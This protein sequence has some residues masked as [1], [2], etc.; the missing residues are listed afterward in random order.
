[1]FAS[2]LVLGVLFLFGMGWS[3]KAEPVIYSATQDVPAWTNQTSPVYHF[4]V[5]QAY[6]LQALY[7]DGNAECFPRM[8]ARIN[9]NNNW[10]FREHYGS[11]YWYQI[12]LWPLPNWFVSNCHFSVATDQYDENTISLYHSVVNVGFKVDTSAPNT[13]THNWPAHNYLNFTNSITLYSNTTTDNGA[14]PAW[15]SGISGYQMRINGSTTY[16][17][18]ASTSKYLDDLSDN[19]YTRQIRA[20]DNAGNRSDWSSS[21]TF[22]IDTTPPSTPS[23]S[24]PANGSMYSGNTV[25][26]SWSSASDTNGI[27]QYAI[28]YT[29]TTYGGTTTSYSAS[30]SAT[31]NFAALTDGVYS[32]R[33]RAQD[34]ATNRWNWSTTRTFIVDRTAPASIA[35]T[36][37]LSNAWIR[38]SNDELLLQYTIT[39][40]LGFDLTYGPNSITIDYSNQWDFVLPTN[41]VSWAPNDGS[42]TRTLPKNQNTNAAKF[43]ITATDL[44]GW[45]STFY[46]S[47]FNIDSIKP[48]DVQFSTPHQSSVYKWWEYISSYI[49]WYD[50]N[51]TSTWT[52]YELLIND[53]HNRYLDFEQQEGGA[54]WF[55]QYKWTAPSDINSQHVKI[56]VTATDK[57]WR[58]NN[59]TSQAFTIDNTA[60][61]LSFNDTSS[62]WTN[63]NKTWSTTVG[64][65]FW[66]RVTGV[67]VY[68]TTAFTNNCDG[69][70][71]TVPV[72]TWDGTYT[73]Y[74]C[75]ADKAGNVTTG[76][77][78]YNIDKTAPYVELTSTTIYTNQTLTYTGIAYDITGN[79]VMSDINT[80]AWSKVSGTGTITFGSPNA[81]TTTISSDTEWLFVLRLTATDHAGNVTTGEMNFVWDVT[82]PILAFTYTN[83]G[84]TNT[85]MTGITTTSDNILLWDIWEPVYSDT[86]FTNNCDDGT[87]GYTTYTDDGIYT[88]YACV[89]DKAG[90]I[91]KVDQTYKIDKTKPYVVAGSITRVNTGVQIDSDIYD[92]LS[93][94]VK[95]D[96]ATILWEKIAGTWEITFTPSTGAQPTI[97]ADTDGTYTLKVTVTDHAGNID[98]DTVLFTRDTTA[99]VVTWG[100]ISQTNTRHP[101]YTFTSNEAGTITYSWSCGNGTI[102]TIVVGTNSYTYWP[103]HNGTTYTGCQIIVADDLGNEA[104]YDIPTF[105]IAVPSFGGWWS[106]IKDYCPNG[107]FS[108][109][110]YDGTCGT[111][112][113]DDEEVED[114][115]DLVEETVEDVITDR[116]QDSPYSEELN[117][118]YLRAYELGITTKGTVM[119]A[120]LESP[121]IRAHMAKMIVEYAKKVLDK[122]PDTSLACEFTDI[123]ELQWQDL[124]EFVIEACQLWLMGLHADGTPNTVFNPFGEVTRA[125]FGTVLSR[126]LYWWVFNTTDTDNRFASHLQALKDNAIM[127]KIENAEL[128]K[129]LRWWVLLMLMRSSK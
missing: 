5:N 99:P 61:T 36:A 87:T 58:T 92:V 11:W 10:S 27:A 65:N 77:Q 24:S 115:E 25:A 94:W 72:Y 3:V 73:V 34:N 37:P 28:E 22:I 30:T 6:T 78:T 102:F 107:D 13:P 40:G 50:A 15:A 54:G 95:S 114:F 66:L 79:N 29:N 63:T 67:A 71:T 51:I 45:S 32:R 52:V 116:L 41:V 4:A 91:K 9:I 8:E 81:R 118:A 89:M 53:V 19:S 84:W 47:P 35:F 74:A 121:L 101:K 33:V 23:L 122:T 106:P 46:S 96:I 113:T 7:M 62:A 17:L 42:Y 97:S 12:T 127:T 119:E 108:D 105:T 80:V 129:E 125:Q 31:L 59:G 39:R 55:G 69:G 16:D 44:M 68:A 38:G 104:T 110:F 2:F 75:V 48:T 49:W 83:S 93:G 100:T 76:E 85:S 90:N 123:D 111:P 117:D 70:I 18:W 1:M 120:D 60:P 14:A 112:P 98:N 20:Q 124:Y 86:A 57:A 103:L 128:T 21:Q 64:D 109:S 82:D 126:L 88:I 56:K 43:R 26:V